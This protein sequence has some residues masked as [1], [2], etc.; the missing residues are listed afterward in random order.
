MVDDY[1]VC[2]YYTV[3]NESGGNMVGALNAEG[4]LVV[5]IDVYKRQA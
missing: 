5:P 2:D 3:Q 4:T 1:G